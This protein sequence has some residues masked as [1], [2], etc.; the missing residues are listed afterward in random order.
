MTSLA[1]M[2]GRLIW[3]GIRGA[4][5]GD[6]TLEAELKICERARVGGV[7]LFNV[8]VPARDH[9]RSLGLAE[10]E[11]RRRAP[12]NIIDPTQTAE[13][14]AYLRHRLG[15]GLMVCVD[16]EGGFVSRLALTRGFPGSPAPADYAR[17]DH[18]TRR[19]AAQTLARTVASVGI[20]MNLA[21]CVDVAVNPEG[22]GHTSLGRSFGRDPSVVASMAAEQIDAMHAAG[23][24]C[25]IKHFPGHGSARGDTH[26]G[27]VDI[28]DTWVEADELLPY[29]VLLPRGPGAPDAVMTSH[30]MHR[31]LDPALPCSL[32]PAVITG[33]LREQLGFQGLVV[34]DSLDM[35]AIS[36][37]CGPGDASVS[38]LLAGADVALEGNNLSDVRPCPAGDMHR[39]ITAAVETGRLPPARIEASVAR[40]R[41]VIE[42][43]HAR[44]RAAGAA[45]A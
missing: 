19:A 27:M 9:Q 10:A 45:R 39:A 40:V 1:D 21:P 5:E 25:C 11:A 23:L 43:I 28:T 31:G 36:N 12:R 41:R 15:A 32:S 13:L 3:V 8:D 35:H 4:H 14:V 34:T 24:A 2:I 16:Q 29:R 17:M 20:D 44:R 33:L 26:F 42:A 22:P 6:P 38:A 37:L 30:L 7:I 18:P